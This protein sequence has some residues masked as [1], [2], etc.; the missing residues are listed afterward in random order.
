MKGIS[1]VIGLTNTASNGINAELTVGDKQEDIN[2]K[3]GETNTIQEAEEITNYVDNI[4]PMVL[5]MLVL[6]WLL[7]SPSEM[8]KG[9]I[10]LFTFGRRKGV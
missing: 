10:N 8:W 2:T 9:L 6:G 7:P 1:S 5:F 3:V 4:P